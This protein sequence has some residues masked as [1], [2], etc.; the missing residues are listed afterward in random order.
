[1]KKIGYN[2]SIC[3]LYCNFILFTESTYFMCLK[4]KGVGLLF[5]SRVFPYRMLTYNLY[6][7]LVVDTYDIHTFRHTAH[8]NIVFRMSY[9]YAREIINFDFCAVIEYHA[10]SVAY[11]VLFLGGVAA[12][13][14]VVRRACMG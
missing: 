1:M 8:V 4:I 12:T 7:F 14:A 6:A 3:Y 5:F 9:I 11:V 10:V 13:L 2:Y